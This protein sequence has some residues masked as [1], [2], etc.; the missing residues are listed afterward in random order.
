M[1]EYWIHKYKY[2]DDKKRKQFRRLLKANMVEIVRD[3]E[4]KDSSYYVY[5]SKTPI[6]IT[7]G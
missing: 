2:S 7:K 4:Y 3:P 6:K 1:K 5:R